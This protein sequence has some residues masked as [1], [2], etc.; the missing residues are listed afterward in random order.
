MAVQGPKKLLAELIEQRYKTFLLNSDRELIVPVLS[1][2]PGVAIS[3]RL[4][5]YQKIDSHPT[6]H[7]VKFITKNDEPNTFVW[8]TS[9]EKLQQA[10]R[11]GIVK[12]H[13]ITGKVIASLGKYRTIAHERVL[14]GLISN[15]QVTKLKLLDLYQDR[16]TALQS[17]ESLVNKHTS[18]E[19]YKAAF[20][21]YR[22]EL[23]AIEERITSY[24]S[25]IDVIGL[26][27]QSFAQ[28]AADIQADRKR[29]DTYWQE[30]QNASDLRPYNRSRGKHSI[31]EFV[32]QQM[33]HGLYELQGINQ[34]MTYSA[35]RYFAL[36]R[37]ELND[38]IEDAR[39]EIEDHEADLRNA[40]TAKHHGIY[41]TDPN[42]LFIYDFSREDMSL[43]RQNQV[44]TAI[45]FIEGWDRLE[46]PKDGVPYV[47]N[48]DKTE[49]LEVYA[50]TRWRTHRSLIAALKSMRSFAFNIVKGFFVSTTPWEEED[51]QNKSFHLQATQLH[52]HVRPNKPFWKKPALF[53]RQLSYALIDVFDGVRDFGAKLVINM[54]EDLVNDWQATMHLPELDLLLKETAQICQ[55]IQQEEKDTLEKALRWCDNGIIKEPSTATIHLADVEYELSAGEFNDILNS[56]VRGLNG[57]GSV[58]SHNIYA[59]DPL[60]GLAFTATYLL[61]IGM[62]Y[63]PA[64]SA[65]IFGSNLVNSFNTI[66]YAMAS[67]PLGAAVA[68]GSTLAEASIV[69]WDGLLHGPSGIALNALY[70]VGEDPITIAAYGAAAYAVGYLLVNGIAGHKIP[71]LSDMLAEDLGTDPSTGYPIIGA[72]VALMGY[73]ALLTHP[74][75]EHKLPDL[76]QLLQEIDYGEHEKQL[77]QFKLIIWLA[78][79]AKMLPKLDAQHRFALIRQIELLFNKAESES[80]KK[81]FYPEKYSSI[82]FQLVAIP[83]S[84]IPALLRMII[85]PALS[86]V[87]WAKG[88]PY[89][90]APVMRAAEFLIDKAKKDLSRLIV[91]TTN[92]TYLVYTLVA[93]PVKMTA[94]LSVM[95]VGR[96]AGLFNAK[97]A[98]ITHRFF[99]SAH[100][101]FRTL[102]EFFYP[103]RAMKEVA[104]AHPTDTMFK[105]NNSY[106]TL[107]TQI[108]QNNDIEEAPTHSRLFMQAQPREHS[109][110]AEQESAA[111]MHILRQS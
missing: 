32:K 16:F 56:I 6:P 65:S 68:G 63:L 12:P 108:G 92:L 45:S 87:A 13:S 77:K 83:L 98:H 18:H 111:S 29:A 67:S 38:V 54:P 61:G 69:A 94:Y 90:Q 106:A 74:E 49:L 52:A 10:V 24:F 9:T 66:S 41:S 22:Q 96:I 1:S 73:E 4:D 44:L 35:N 72:K 81:L 19:E 51:W 91:V 55:Q 80:L 11:W 101:F 36:T 82:A 42:E 86:L 43:V 105:V 93:T 70:Q 7:H 25:Q 5:I 15:S 109:V 88:N 102:G 110:L 75:L 2:M 8:K 21:K 23:Q 50:A 26:D 20:A 104:S 71:V 58:F 27:K 103:V 17:L 48:G 53:L 100:N 46:T 34:D 59:K 37:G 97:P 33:V 40:V 39:K 60:G 107:L 76:Q 31:L 99:A 89:P 3:K 78:G 85:A 57:F 62:I 95:A 30:L 28:I 64:Y 79:H 47:S 14:K 84:Y